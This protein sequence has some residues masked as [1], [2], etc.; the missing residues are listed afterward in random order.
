LIWTQDLRHHTVLSLE[1]TVLAVLETHQS[2]IS[3]LLTLHLAQVR[4]R[5]KS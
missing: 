5:A 1:T 2:Q 3:V 4:K